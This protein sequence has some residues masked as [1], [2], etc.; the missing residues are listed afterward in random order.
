[1][2]QFVRPRLSFAVGTECNR[3]RSSRRSRARRW[4]GRNLV[5]LVH[6]RRNRRFLRAAAMLSV[7]ALPAKLRAATPLTDFEDGTTQGWQNW[8]NPRIAVPDPTGTSSY[9]LKL[10]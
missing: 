4:R 10:D 6:G 5:T 8:S 2:V 9:M 7:A 1:M 3:M